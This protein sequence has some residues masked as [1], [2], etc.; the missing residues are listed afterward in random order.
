MQVVTDQTFGLAELFGRTS[1]VR[2]GPNDRTFFAEHRTFFV[3]NSM[4][5][6]SFH[7]LVL[8]YDPHMLSL[9]FMKN[10]QKN[11]NRAKIGKLTNLLT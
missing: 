4:P 5:L 1:T 6:A 7:I 3:S 2:F 11:A 8:L 9:A 10:S